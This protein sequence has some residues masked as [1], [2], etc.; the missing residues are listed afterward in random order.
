MSTVRPEVWLKAGVTLDGRIADAFGRSQWITGPEARQAGHHLRG[1]VDAVMVGS[2]TLLADDPSLNTRVP[3]LDNALPVVLD[4]RLRCPADARVLVAGRRALVFCADD[5]PQRALEADIERVPRGPGGGLDL[6]T[7][8]TRLHSRGVRTLLVEG[9]GQVHRSLLEL[10]VADVL[11]L[12]VAPLALAGGP[13]W[14]A[15]PGIPLNDARR[16]HFDS[17]EMVGKD[18]HLVLR[19]TVVTQGETRSTEVG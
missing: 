13:G 19:R 17:V 16:W 11:H 18:A 2:G 3:G 15:G 12:F 5:A 6:P 14:L 10:D 9:G 7:V 4:T 8:L 1:E